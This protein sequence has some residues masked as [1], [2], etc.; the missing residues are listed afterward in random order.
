MAVLM[1]SLIVVEAGDCGADE[2]YSQDRE[3]SIRN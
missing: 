3:G 2:N 1:N